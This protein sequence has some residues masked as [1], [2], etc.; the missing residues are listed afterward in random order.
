MGNAGEYDIA[1]NGSGGQIN[2]PSFLIDFV[3]GS[4]SYRRSLGYSD[5]KTNEMLA[6]A[7]LP[8]DEDER[9]ALYDEVQRHLLEEAPI[10][11]LTTR[12]QAFA[13]STSVEGFSHLPGFL[14][15][16]SGYSLVNTSVSGN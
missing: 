3:S 13:Y 11:P 10:V 6:A 12:A 4:D 7:L 5:E 9:K 1:I 16:L 8:E 15:F 2:D 14:S